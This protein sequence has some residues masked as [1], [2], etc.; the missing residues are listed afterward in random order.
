M[1]NQ[2]D[3]LSCIGVFNRPRPDLLRKGNR[4]KPG[5]VLDVLSVASHCCVP[6]PNDDVV[7]Y[8]RRP[9]ADTFSDAS[10]WKFDKSERISIMWFEGDP[11][12]PIF[13]RKYS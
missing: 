11:L 6:I 2:P 8:T 13:S 9:A 3:N 7:F 5:L 1:I 10:L 4:Q 12:G